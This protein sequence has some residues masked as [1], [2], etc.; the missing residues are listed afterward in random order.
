MTFINFPDNNSSIIFK[1]SLKS[2]A[3]IT[4]IGTSFVE[5]GAV[6]TSQGIRA[7]SVGACRFRGF[8]GSGLLD[9]AGQ[10]S[11]E[12][13]TPAI[14]KRWVPTGSEGDTYTVDTYLYS[15]GET[16]LPYGRMW[17]NI[18]NDMN[19]EM[20]TSDT[21]ISGIQSH[22]FRNPA[23]SIVTVSW[24]DDGNVIYYINQRKHGEGV[25][26]DLTAPMFNNI[27]MGSN[28]SG[29]GGTA[30][31]EN[32]ILSDFI[33]AS[34]PVK[35]LSVPVLSNL[36]YFGDSYV[37]QADVAGATFFRNN[38]RHVVDAVTAGV[39]ALTDGV[40][41]GH[42][43]ATVHDGGGAPLDA[44]RAAFIATNPNPAVFQA[45]VN[46]S[47]ETTLHANYEV[48]LD[49]HLTSIIAGMTGPLFLGTVP[50]VKYA[51]GAD[52]PQ[53]VANVAEANA[54]T[55]D[56]PARWDAANPA[57][58]GRII[59]YDLHKYI[60]GENPV[61]DVFVGQWNGNGDDVHFTAKGQK[62]WGEVLGSAVVK[63]IGLT[64]TT[65]QQLIKP[66]I[67]RPIRKVIRGSS[68][69]IE[70]KTALVWLDET[71]LVI[72]GSDVTDWENKGTGGAT[73]DL[74][75]QTNGATL[76]QVGVFNGL[77]IADLSLL[78]GGNRKHFSPSAPTVIAQPFSIFIVAK[79]DVLPGAQATLIDSTAGT[80]RVYIDAQQSSTSFT[81]SAGNVFTSGAGTSDA[82]PHIFASRADGTN[83][84]FSV[85][86]I[87]DLTPFDTGLNE[88]SY[89]TLG[90]NLNKFQTW[91]GWIGEVIIL[92]F[93]VD[94][95]QFKSINDYLKPKWGIA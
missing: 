5:A 66:V 61:D 48:D 28:R 44:F 74:I 56:A 85:S 89:V 31:L 94:A 55:H 71:T 11:F 90:A 53:K 76:P 88:L 26:S 87:T 84:G 17:I 20:N 51:T 75:G 30:A 19:F 21:H 49:D 78:P 25:R 80:D 50:T 57:D 73:Y 47:L 4:D 77:N 35:L 79:L 63:L 67:R 62:M 12:I 10:L 46:D 69:P 18:N 8:A 9:T 86:S 33:I 3:S 29:A 42:S 24:D 23:R 39:G 14:S 36:S 43:G 93:A 37:G 1:S 45:G 72:S 83:G 60:G 95:I 41:D 59:V 32:A 58:K 22:S 52:I 65:G 54:I 81:F 6:I 16:G 64:G 82:Q 15:H 68:I 40:V 13:D 27:F 91:D 70:L 34:V 38:A 92:P 2:A 7:G